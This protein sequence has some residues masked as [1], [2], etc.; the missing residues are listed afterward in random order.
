M[1]LNPKLLLYASVAFLVLGVIDI[2]ERHRAANERNQLLR[3]QRDALDGI[4][5]RLA[6]H[7]PFRR[8]VEGPAESSFEPAHPDVH[9]DH[10]TPEY[11]EGDDA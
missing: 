2:I 9:V 10:L 11:E 6:A 7:F 1:T 5:M 4:E 3:E 8:E